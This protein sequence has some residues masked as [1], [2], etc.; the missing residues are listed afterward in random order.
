[1]SAASSDEK[2][3]LLTTCLLSFPLEALKVATGNVTSAPSVD[4][5]RTSRRYS[6]GGSMESTAGVRLPSSKAKTVTGRPLPLTLACTNS[7]QL[8][9]RISRACSASYSSSFLVMM[10]SSKWCWT[11]SITS[12]L[13]SASLTFMST[14]SQAGISMT[15]DEA[16]KFSTSCSTSS[17]HCLRLWLSNSLSASRTNLESTLC[18]LAV[19]IA[20]FIAIVLPR[21]KFLPIVLRISSTP[22]FTLYASSSS[23]EAVISE[24]A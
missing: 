11:R 9:L 24:S 19:W 8:R 5:V 4:S 3:L 2:P 13:H 7:R 14:D 12:A 20:S 6:N 23:D 18:F 16:K 22:C 17:C 15:C 21:F 1:M 10:S